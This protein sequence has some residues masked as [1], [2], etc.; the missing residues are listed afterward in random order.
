MAARTDLHGLHE[1]NIIMFSHSMNEIKVEMHSRRLG[2][3]SKLNSGLS[4]HGVI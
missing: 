3:F 1:E 2:W 4:S